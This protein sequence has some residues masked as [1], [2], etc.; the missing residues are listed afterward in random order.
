MRD[1]SIK[2]FFRRFIYPRVF[3]VTLVDAK[4]GERKRLVFKALDKAEDTGRFFGKCKET[5]VIEHDDYDMNFG[6]RRALSHTVAFWQKFIS[7]FRKR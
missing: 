1:F 5:I 2:R 4:T 6:I 3:D 7:S